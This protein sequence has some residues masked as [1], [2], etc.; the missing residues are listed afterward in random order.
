MNAWMGSERTCDITRF[1]GQAEAG[2][3]LGREEGNE[4]G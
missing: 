4:W 3:G 2:G 1:G